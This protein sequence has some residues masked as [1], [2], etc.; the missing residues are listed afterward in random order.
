PLV[1]YDAACRMLAEA[2]RVD[3]VKH[4]LDLAA[5]MQEY[6]R[7][8][9]NRDAEADAV[10]IRLNATRRLGEV[11]KGQQDSV[12]FNRGA[13]GGG[14]KAGS[15]GSLINPRDLRP[16]LASQGINKA[17]AHQARVLVAM[18][19]VAFQRKVAE[20][21]TSAARVYHRAIREVEIAQERE[22]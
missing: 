6:A 4:I 13:A 16:T 21:R 19:E 20:A 17:L 9:K 3:D 8:A 1:P 10:A 5:A 11:C 2:V 18:D 22:Q 15:R 12:G 7:R 14:K